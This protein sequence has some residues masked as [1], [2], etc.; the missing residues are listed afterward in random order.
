MDTVIRFRA[1]SKER[2]L[3]E[4]AAQRANQTLSEWMRVI[5]T[6]AAKR[7]PEMVTVD[8]TRGASTKLSGRPPEITRA[9]NDGHI[10]VSS[11][12]GRG[13]LKRTQ[14]IPK[15]DWKK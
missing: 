5:L 11:R 6:D 9:G 10:H 4:N 3:F 8:P 15:P 12:T 7:D 2:A 1:T 13:S 14:T